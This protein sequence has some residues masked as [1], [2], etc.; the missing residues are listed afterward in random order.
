M[1]SL[2]SRLD[3]LHSSARGSAALQRLAIVS[4]IMLALSFIPTGVVKLQGAR[5]SYLS[6]DNPVGAFFEAMFQTGM[7]WRF[8]GLA[9]LVAGILVLIPRTTVLGAVMF[10]PIVLNIFIITIAIDFK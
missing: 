9:Q 8:L 3:R 2:Q 10:F 4:R 5:F 6:V 1:S 7:Y